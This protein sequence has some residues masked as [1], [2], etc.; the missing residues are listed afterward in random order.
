ML[1]GRCQRCF[2]EVSM[3]AKTGGFK[4]VFKGVSKAIPFISGGIRGF[5]LEHPKSSHNSVKSS[6]IPLALTETLLERI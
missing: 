5:P 3:R 6:G 4:G 1:S 2:S